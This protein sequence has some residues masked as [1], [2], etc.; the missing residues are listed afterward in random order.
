[1]EDLGR[2]SGVEA[3]M[4]GS[5]AL[6]AADYAN[7]FSSYAYIYHQKQMLTDGRR[8]RAYREAIVGNARAFRGKV[9]LDVGA[10]SGI[11]SIWAA[12]AGAAR[13][14]ACEFTGMA[15]LGVGVKN[16]EHTATKLRQAPRSS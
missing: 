4:T 11:L 13:V 14:I 10:G 3:L 8:M 12:Q 6:Q 5:P 2:K 9:V 1:M 7:Y 15:E 16:S